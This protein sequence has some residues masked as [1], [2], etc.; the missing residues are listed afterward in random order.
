MHKSLNPDLPTAGGEMLLRWKVLACLAAA[1][2]WCRPSNSLTDI[3]IWGAGLFA[4]WNWRRLIAVW[5]NPAGRLLGLGTVWAA[6]SVCWSFNRG[7]TAED[8]LEALPLVL[9]TLAVSILFDRASR[10]WA[11]LL[12]SAG[13]VTVRLTWD[14]IRLF[15]EL[16]WP[17][18]MTEARYIH[19]YLYTHPNVSCMMAVLCLLIFLG[20]LLARPRKGVWP[21]IGALIGMGLNLAYLVV[22]ASRGPQIVFVLML[23]LVPLVFLPGWR[24]RL[25]A[26]LVLTAA[27]CG[28][29]KTAAV[30]NPRFQD[31]T[32]TNFN[33][34]D[35]VWGH[36]M[37]LADRKPVL[38]YGFGKRAFQSA[39]YD[40]PD[41]RPPLVPFRY[42]HAH[43][44]W[45]MLYF[46]GGLIGFVLWSS[47]W[48]ALFIR[49]C[50]TRLRLVNEMGT[51]GDRLRAGVLPGLLG[52][53]MLAVLV[54]GVGDYPDHVIRRSL[55][56]LLG[57]TMAM[58]R[59]QR[60]EQQAVL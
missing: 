37:L 41:Q 42:P 57:L 56:Y 12:V 29:W 6:V 55:F 2:F 31:R 28:L 21:V 16:G 58:T 44:Y 59:V 24:S 8:L 40:N 46:Q 43:Q 11:A 45:L 5:N 48:A 10:I 3:L 39:V 60:A 27:V 15:R 7:G 9:S 54:Y 33:S 26:A 23:L 50:R 14:L 35:T 49:L 34:R 22:L 4:I 32:M 36:S 52:L 53:C 38:G 25:V 20:S 18:V 13:W 30:I 51:W 17:T 47:G 1:W 19:P